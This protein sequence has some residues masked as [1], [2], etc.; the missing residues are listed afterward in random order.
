MAIDTTALNTALKSSLQTGIKAFFDKQMSASP[1]VTTDA[2]AQDLANR[3]SDALTGN[4]E[5][6][7][8]TATVSVTVLNAAVSIQPVPPIP[9]LVGSVGHQ[10]VPNSVTTPGGIS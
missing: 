5:T 2:A 10:G 4:L 9:P 6:W 1:N 3:L 7:I 8:K